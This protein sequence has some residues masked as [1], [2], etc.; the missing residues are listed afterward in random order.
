[1]T[2]F[3]AALD[4]ITR[5]TKRQSWLIRAGEEARAINEH[6]RSTGPGGSGD[7]QSRPVT[8]QGESE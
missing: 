8:I 7:A 4:R 6:N 2:P 5:T 1:M 3:S